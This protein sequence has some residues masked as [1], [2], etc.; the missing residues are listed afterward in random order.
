MGLG[1][2]GQPDGNEN[3]GEAGSTRMEKLANWV[4][5][6]L[7][8]P[9]AHQG[10]KRCLDGTHRNCHQTG[11]NMETSTDRKECVPPPFS[12]LQFPVSIP[13]ADIGAGRCFAECQL[14]SQ[15]EAQKGAFGAHG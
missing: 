3:F 15:S 14:A 13:V 1:P 12:A 9:A 10:K 2:S 8:G 5:M 11:G 4:Q 7:E 6:L